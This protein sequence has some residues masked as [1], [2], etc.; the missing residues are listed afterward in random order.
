MFQR[1]NLSGGILNLPD[2]VR[3]PSALPVIRLR[4]GSAGIVSTGLSLSGFCIGSEGIVSTGLSWSGLRLF[5][6]LCVLRGISRF[7]LSSLGIR[8]R[9]L[10]FLRKTPVSVC[11][12]YDRGR[13]NGRFS[14]HV[15]L[16][17]LDS[18]L[19]S[20]LQNWQRPG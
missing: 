14:P 4:V 16:F 1:F 12:S 19:I 3:V 2:L 5:S 13:Y 20:L 6:F 18:N 15:V 8:R 10:L 11:T 17:G 7:S 9:C